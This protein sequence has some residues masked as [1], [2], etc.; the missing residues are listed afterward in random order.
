MGEK[1]QEK[2]IDV[3]LAIDF[4]VLALQDKYDV[5]ILMSSDTDLRP[6]LET[7]ISLSSKKVEVTAW[8]GKRP[9]KRLQLPE[10][11]IWCHWLNLEAYKTCE[12]PH[13]YSQS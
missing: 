1:P 8:K 12:D 10:N 11:N 3:A 9:N 2:G 13:N 7:V 6:A 5:G 4:V